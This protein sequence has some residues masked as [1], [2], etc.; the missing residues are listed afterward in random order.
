MESLK[1]GETLIQTPKWFIGLRVAQILVSLII[2]G[3]A[4]SLIHGYYADSLGFAIA[5]VSKICPG[6]KGRV[7]RT[8]VQ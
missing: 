6:A 1:K 8:C 5:S 3:L 7:K 2:V 4:G